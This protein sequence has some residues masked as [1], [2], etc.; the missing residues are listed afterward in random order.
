MAFHLVDRPDFAAH[1][2]GHRGYS[3]AASAALHAIIALTLVVTWQLTRT[4]TPSPHTDTTVRRLVYIPHIEMGGGRT[5]GGDRSVAQP[6]RIRETGDAEVSAPARPAPSDQMTQATPLDATPIPVKPMGEALSPL[7]GTIDGDRSALTGGPGLTGSG[8]SVGK[9]RGAAGNQPGPGFGDGVAR[10]GG[11]GVTTP[12]VLEQAKPRYTADA[13][14]L[15]IQGSVWVEC[16]V[17]EDGTVT[18][19]HVI[20]SLDSRYGLD[21][22][23][24]AAAKRWRFRPGTLS[25]KPVPVVVT[26]ELLF[27]IR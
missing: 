1:S 15:R 23:A 14:R 13:M 18:D 27:H 2:I 24:I 10:A 25:G 6:R 3:A 5:S 22:E 17:R 8:T 16:I 9:D 12:T 20:R 21:D 7:V 11:P 26:I 4:S 19:A